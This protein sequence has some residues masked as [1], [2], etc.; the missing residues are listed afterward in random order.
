L[1]EAYTKGFGEGRAAGEGVAMAGFYVNNNVTIALRCFAL[2]I[3]G[4]LGS[5]FYLI[6][7]G[8]SIGAVLGYVSSQGAGANILTFM[9][10]HG[11]LELTAIV[12]AGSAGLSLGWSV[13]SP[14]D[15]T[16]AASLQA[17][18]RDVA[19]IAFGAAAMLLLAAAI[20]AFWSGSSVPSPVK[21]GVGATLWTVVLVYLALFGRGAKKKRKGWI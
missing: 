15:R 17:A 7:N 4:G 18:G 1:T 5:A 13:V 14:G 8:L 19:V 21:R 10:G 2:G 9:V 6:D 11:S 12:L 20:E 16:R 3:F